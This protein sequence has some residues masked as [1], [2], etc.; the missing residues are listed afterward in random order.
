MYFSKENAVLTRHLNFMAFLF[1][2]INC[3]EWESENWCV[4]ACASV[5]SRLWKYVLLINI[6]K[7]LFSYLIYVCNFCKCQQLILWSST[8]SV[9]GLSADFLWVAW[10][11]SLMWLGRIYWV[12]WSILC[13]QLSWLSLL[14]SSSFSVQVSSPRHLT[15]GLLV[16]DPFHWTV[17]K[18]VLSEKTAVLGGFQLT[19]FLQ[20]VCAGSLGKHGT[21]Y[22]NREYELSTN[23]RQWTQCSSAQFSW[24]EV[25]EMVVSKLKDKSA[26]VGSFRS[27]NY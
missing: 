10:E 21:L 26:D 4:S 3:P 24:R 16:S 11:Y 7:V 8:L 5:W 2:T 20:H 15:D 23:L 1:D 19:L 22:F 6:F 12:C 17:N 25:F 27:R 14:V 9:T 18:A 13:I